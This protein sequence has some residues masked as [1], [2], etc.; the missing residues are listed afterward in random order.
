[1]PT[2]KLTTKRAIDALKHPSSGQQFYWDTELVGFGVLV[3]IKTKSFILQRD[4]NG[5]SRR[6]NLGRYPEISLHKA[7]QQAEKL[8]GQMRGGSDPIVEQRKKTAD[9]MTLREAWALY[10]NYLTTKER[11]VKT[12]NDYLGNLER[13]CEHWLDRPLIEIT[14]TAARL[15]HAHISKEHGK[16]SANSC[17]RVIRAVWNRARRQHRELPEPP[18]INIDFHP[19]KGRTAVIKVDDLPAW[20]AGLQMIE[21]PIRRDFYIWLL[22][23]GTRRE[24]SSTLEWRNVNLDK[25][26]VHF[27]KTKTEPFDLPLSDY[28]VTLLQAR[29]ACEVT[30]ATFAKSEWVFPAFGTTGHIMEPQL[31]AKERKLFPCPWSPHTLR[32]TYVS[33]AE[34]KAALAPMHARLLVNHAVPR[35]MDSHVG[36]IH[37]DLD[38]LRRSQQLMTDYLLSAI[39]PRDASGKV[40]KLRG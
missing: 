37:P 15:L 9:N 32:H 39:K 27:P 16:Y 21:N 28:L 31:N 30:K 20:W 25:R 18:T 40:V 33:I 13:Y 24:E 8:G 26:C 35:A 1:M 3:G 12:R 4:V 17:A 38:D 7:R 6:I 14:P 22:F 23:T 11:S 2:A 19:E 5:R 29:H 10:D 34:N 36:Y